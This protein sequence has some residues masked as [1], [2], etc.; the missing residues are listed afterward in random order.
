VS[1]L[2]EVAG[3]LDDARHEVLSS[4][5]WCSTF[6]D[7]KAA[8][9]DVEAAELSRLIRSALDGFECAALRGR[10]VIEEAKR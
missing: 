6:V 5:V 3:E 1:E 7:R 10:T 8:E 9:G 2:D 4:L